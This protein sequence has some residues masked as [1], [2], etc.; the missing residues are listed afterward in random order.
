MNN[1]PSPVR[2]LC[3]LGLCRKR[4]G[5]LHPR[6]AAHSDIGL[7]KTNE[8]L[9]FTEDHC[10]LYVALDGIGGQSGGASAS[11][12]ALERLKSSIESMCESA[13]GHPNKD[14]Q[15]AVAAAI[16]AASQEMGQVAQQ[17]PEYDR[18]G[19][20]FALAYI[21]DDT[22]LYTHVGDAR[23]YVVRQ[24][25]AMQLTSDETYV[26]TL[27]DVGAIEPAE[28]PRHPMRNVV[29][30]AVGTRMTQGPT[31]VHSK[32]LLPGDTVLLTTDGVSDK[33]SDDDL[34]KL[35][36]VD[37]A[38]EVVAKAVVKAALEAGASDNASC[39]VVRIDGAEVVQNDQHDKLHAELINLHSMLGKV[40]SVDD[41]LR[42]DM[43]RIATDIR[44]TLHANGHSGLH[45]L[46]SELSDR[47]LEFEVS[48]PHLT[49]AVASI[50]NLLAGIGI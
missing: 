49:S 16:S 2:S 48:H 30:N 27:V 46:R 31:V 28:V 44:D 20:V 6:A 9:V 23:V 40:D 42:S 5:Q 15:E 38:P 32:R 45:E 1:S 24:G 17:I 47:A 21:V 3:S 18:M 35:L 41:Q 36:S 12:I 39:V 14:L 19:T 13:S 10:R 11:R 37:K 29:L 8:D 25:R 43:Q 34:S 26:Q 33:L 50:A 7:R 4:K 22:L